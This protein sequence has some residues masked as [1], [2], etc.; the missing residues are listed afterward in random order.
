MLIELNVCRLWSVR[1]MQRQDFWGQELVGQLRGEF[2][3]WRRRKSKGQITRAVWRPVS[4]YRPCAGV[5]VTTSQALGG[6]FGFLAIADVGG[7]LE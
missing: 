7:L 5:G 4:C 3:V 2:F 1:E 6:T